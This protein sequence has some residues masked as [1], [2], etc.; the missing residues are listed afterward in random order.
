M[1]PLAARLAAWG[2]EKG[3]RSALVAGGG[4][5]GFKVGPIVGWGRTSD[6]AINATA[7]L[8]IERGWLDDRVGS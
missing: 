7:D 2:A 8:L 4:Q 5:V 6:Q 3:W 1:K